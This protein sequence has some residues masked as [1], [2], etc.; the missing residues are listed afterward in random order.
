M[1]PHRMLNRSF[2]I[3]PSP[4]PLSLFIYLSPRYKYVVWLSIFCPQRKFQNKLSTFHHVEE[5]KK[6]KKT[7][8]K[9]NTISLF[10][11]L[12]PDDD[13]ELDY[14]QLSCIASLYKCFI[15]KK[16]KNYI[17]SCL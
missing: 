14:Y 16:N 1:H 7:Q 2:H 3:F 13:D 4:S 11:S 9:T 6:K 5:T 8:K 17:T 15:Y 12:S 10:Q